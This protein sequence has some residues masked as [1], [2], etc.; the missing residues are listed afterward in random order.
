MN[1]GAEG[2]HKGVLAGEAQLVADIEHERP[3]GR[4]LAMSWLLPGFG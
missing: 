2:P 3:P 4:A 1:G